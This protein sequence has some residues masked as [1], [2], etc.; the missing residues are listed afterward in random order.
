MDAEMRRGTGTA[1]A[2]QYSAVRYLSVQHNHGGRGA[3]G[4]GLAGG[5]MRGY[6]EGGTPSTLCLSRES[7]VVGG[8]VYSNPPGWMQVFH[9]SGSSA[10]I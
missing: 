3:G 1:V 4:W 9:F 6:P 7:S 2:V 5:R 10:A 8:V